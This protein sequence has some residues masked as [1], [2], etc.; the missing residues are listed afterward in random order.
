MARPLKSSAEA[1]SRDSVVS[2]WFCSDARRSSASNQRVN[3][4]RA[5][6]TS[7]AMN[8]MSH[9]RRV[10]PLRKTELYGL[11]LMTPSGVAS[12]LLRADFTECQPRQMRA[13]SRLP[14]HRIQAGLFSGRF[15]EGNRLVGLQFRKLADGRIGI[16]VDAPSAAPRCTQHAPGDGLRRDGAQGFAAAREHG[17]DE[18][19]QYLAGQ[20]QRAHLLAR[21]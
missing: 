17:I 19:R 6:G 15:L 5:T 3:N 14:L 12:S 1:R 2:S 10:R 11:P 4:A 18:R 13:A 8:M 20:F 9:S 7:M 21:P 16:A